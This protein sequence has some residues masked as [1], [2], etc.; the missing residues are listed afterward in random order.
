MVGDLFR[1]REQPEQMSSVRSTP[2]L[3]RTSKEKKA[4]AGKRTRW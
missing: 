1:P 3:S 2:G 4:M